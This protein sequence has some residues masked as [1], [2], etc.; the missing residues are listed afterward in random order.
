MA[1]S[2]LFAVPT[3]YLLFPNPVMPE[4]IRMTHL[5]ETLPYQFLFGSILHRIV[6]YNGKPHLVDTHIGR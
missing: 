4:E 3:I 5:V 1:V 2:F 6:I